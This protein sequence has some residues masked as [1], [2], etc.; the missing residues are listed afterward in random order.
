MPPKFVMP[1]QSPDAQMGGIGEGLG[2]LAQAFVGP[3]YEE[4]MKAD[5]LKSGTRKQ[6]LE[7]DQLEAQIG[8][9]KATAQHIQSGGAFDPRVLAGHLVTGLKDPSKIG[10]VLLGLSSIGPVNDRTKANLVLGAGKT[11][12]VNDA[13]SLDDRE[14]VAGRNQANTIAT[15]NVDNTA[16]MDRHKM[17]VAEQQRAAMAAQ[18]TERY[19]HETGMDFG[20]RK[21]FDQL[22]PAL[23]LMAVGPDKSHAEGSIIAA[24]PKNVQPATVL[25]QSEMGKN[26]TQHSLMD[27]SDPN[28]PLLQQAINNETAGKMG[29]QP[30][31]IKLTAWLSANPQHERRGEIEARLKKL[32]SIG[33]SA[34]MSPSVAAGVLA[35]AG[36]RK[37]MT[38]GTATE[39]DKARY[40]MAYYIT[41]RESAKPD[42]NG[43]FL[44][45]ALPSNLPAP[46]Y[47][48]QPAAPVDGQPGQPGQQGNVIKGGTGQPDRVSQDFEQILPP[49]NLDASQRGKALEAMN[50]TAKLSGSVQTLRQ[51]LH[52]RGPQVKLWNTPEGMRQQAEYTDLLMT[53]KEHLNLGVLNGPDLDVLRGYVADPTSITSAA[54]SLG[55][56]RFQQGLMQQLDVLDN[57]LRADYAKNEGLLKGVA[58]QLPPSYQPT[59]KP[60]AAQQP[61]QGHGGG[62]VKWGRGADGKPARVQ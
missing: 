6:T 42:G 3:T 15:H 19:K 62:V 21:A 20:K 57:K 53:L 11:I 47:R 48:G 54:R 40:D 34:D 44:R 23:K 55:P 37:R 24:L 13:V 39:D 56:E 46:S 33:V 9:T 43:G 32:G 52:E 16:A 49:H 60:G 12:G 27:N 35:D 18:A 5:Y 50:N 1:Y 58:P 26:I 25:P 2:A 30:E 29:D 51:S 59:A 22:D 41:V 61:Q 17:T 28:K 45:A 31:V 10:E 7:G 8:G 38:E 14:S 4:R 36:L